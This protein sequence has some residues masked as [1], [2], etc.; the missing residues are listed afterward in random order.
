M[1]ENDDGLFGTP[2]EREFFDG[3]PDAREQQRPQPQP[4][5]PAPPPVQVGIVDKGAIFKPFDPKSGVVSRTRKARIIVHTGDKYEDQT[6]IEE[7]RFYGDDGRI[8]DETTFRRDPATGLPHHAETEVVCG[9]GRK[10]YIGGMLP[11][12]MDK[13]VRICRWCAQEEED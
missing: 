2:R 13:E 12:L 6:V 5:T 10:C 9:C 11:S 3:A 7:T 1:A 8:F 4:M